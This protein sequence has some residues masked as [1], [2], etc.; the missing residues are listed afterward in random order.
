MDATLTLVGPHGP[1]RGG[2]PRGRGT[3]TVV[4]LRHTLT[5]PW[6]ASTGRASGAPRHAPVVVTK[7]LD[8][9]SPLLAE[10]WASNAVL[11]SWRLEVLGTDGL[12]RRV[13]V[14]AVE[15]RRAVVVQI[16]VQTPEDG[17]LPLESVSFA[18]ERITWTW[19]AGNVTA[20][21]GWGPP[22]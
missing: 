7:E 12:G 4:E 10:A 22:T 2:D 3:I 9:A 1:V 13:P 17:E 21:A 18:Y 20:T 5:T 19:S 16:V 14:Y 6:D 8:R 11:T 15:L